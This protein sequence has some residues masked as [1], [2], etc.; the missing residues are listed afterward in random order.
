MDRPMNELKD[1]RHGRMLFN[2]HDV[3]IGRSLDLYGEFSEGECEVFRQLIRVGWTVLELGANIGTHTVALAKMVGPNGRVIAFEPQRIVYQNLCANIALNSIL[4]VDCHLQAVGETLGSVIVPSLD[5][6]KDNNFGGLGLGAYTQ[7]VAVPVVTVDSLELNACHFIKMD[8]EGMEREAILGARKTIDRFKPV[9]YLEND[10]EDR[11]AA[12]I[13]TLHEV[14]Y[15]M[16]WHAPPLFNQKNFFA[17][18]QNIF[19]GIVSKN[20]LCIHA[21]IDHKIDAPRVEVPQVVN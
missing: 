3:Y 7:G 16:Y 14:G 12:L 20:M 4:N 5:Y 13:T 11:S 6:T 15:A 19:G 10:R 21:S 8:I 9:L 2:V 17:N 18:E 1:C